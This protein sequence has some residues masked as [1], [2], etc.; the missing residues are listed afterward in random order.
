MPYILVSIPETIKKIQFVPLSAEE[1]KVRKK[2]AEKKYKKTDKGKAAGRAAGK[3]YEASDKG[4]AT[5]ERYK[6]KIESVLV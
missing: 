1:K 5:R 4:K 3:R 6:L 2:A